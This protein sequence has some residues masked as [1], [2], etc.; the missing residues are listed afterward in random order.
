MAN[1]DAHS[2]SLLVHFGMVE[3]EYYTVLFGVSRVLGVMASLCWSRALGFP[4][5]RP[6]SVT[7][8]LVKKWLKGEII[9]GE[10]REL[11]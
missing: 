8:E 1:V 6:K 5:E 9:F 7:T 11:C 2:G 4:I 10:S 3:Y